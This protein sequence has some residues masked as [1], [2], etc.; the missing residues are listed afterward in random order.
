LFKYFNLVVYN[1]LTINVKLNCNTDFINQLISNSI[2]L[3]NKMCTE[4]VFFLK[5]SYCGIF[6][7]A[8]KPYK[9]SF[10]PT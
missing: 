6:I 9:R 7:K 8:A 10:Y 5:N 2:P 3:N 4:H 1:V